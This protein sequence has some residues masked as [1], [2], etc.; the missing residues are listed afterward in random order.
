[1][2]RI[3]GSPK[4]AIS[5]AITF[6]RFNLIFIS[7]QFPILN[8]EG[9]CPASKL[10]IT[11]FG[12]GLGGETESLGIRQVYLAVLPLKTFGVCPNLRNYTPPAPFL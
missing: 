5:F 8:G 3:F 11:T 9:L 7:N 1:M 4:S 6:G 2:T 12:R 10:E